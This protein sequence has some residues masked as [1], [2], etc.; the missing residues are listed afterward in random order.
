M[1]SSTK[2]KVEIAKAESWRSTETK[3]GVVASDLAP[4]HLLGIKWLDIRPWEMS[5]K[6]TCTQEEQTNIRSTF[7]LGTT[8][9]WTRST[10][11]I[12]YQEKAH[13][14]H[15][16]CCTQLPAPFGELRVG[17]KNLHTEINSSS[18]QMKRGLRATIWFFLLKNKA[19]CYIFKHENF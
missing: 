5:H 8:H 19:L 7:P 16:L 18:T 15:I 4:S 14:P 11:M 17:W 1:C 10:R 6:V 9:I 3:K 13:P 12:K 2:K